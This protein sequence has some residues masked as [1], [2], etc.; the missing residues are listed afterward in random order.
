MGQKRNSVVEAVDRYHPLICGGFAGSILAAHSLGFHDLTDKF[1]HLQ[2]PISPSPFPSSSELY[3]GRGWDDVYF[4]S[5]MVCVIAALRWAYRQSVLE[6]TARYLN[7]TRSLTSKW[8]DVGWVAI[9]YAVMW[10]WGIYIFKDDPWFF[11]TKHF[12]IGYP[13]VL[14]RDFKAF[15]LIQ[16]SFWIANLGMFFLE[17]QRR[18]YWQFLG[19]HFV[20]I[21]LIVGS[22]YYHFYRI[23]AAVLL[24]QDIGD[25]FYYHVKMI[26]YAGYEKSATFGFAVFMLIWFFTRHVLY[27]GILYSVWVEFQQFFPSLPGVYAGVYLS[28]TVWLAFSF[29]LLAL[30]GLLIF[31]FVMIVRLAIRV[32]NGYETKDETDDLSEEEEKVVSNSHKEGSPINSNNEVHTD[33]QGKVSTDLDGADTKGSPNLAEKKKQ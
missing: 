32:L 12:W 30:Q 6:A 1:V 29:G 3:Y 20:T 33:C 23:G 24:V 14:D 15:Y 21:S 11:E 9:Y 10:S 28:R 19:H 8:M 26:K 7:F 25:V 4:V 27:G 22:Y 5:L 17:A 16:L 31:W 2:F 13:H 18:D